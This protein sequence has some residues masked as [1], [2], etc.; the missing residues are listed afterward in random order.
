M[1]S[2]Q[3]ESRGREEHQK[4]L[5]RERREKLGGLLMDDMGLSGRAV[6]VQAVRIR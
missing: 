4:R 6:D 3:R 5:G 2:V 1:R